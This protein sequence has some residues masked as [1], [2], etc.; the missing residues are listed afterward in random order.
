MKRR[1]FFGLL[2]AAVGLVLFAVAAE[3]H[4]RA[5]VTPPNSARHAEVLATGARPNRHR[6]STSLRADANGPERSNR[7]ETFVE[8]QLED[9]FDAYQIEPLAL[10][11]A[12]DEASCVAACAFD[13]VQAAHRLGAV[14][15]DDRLGATLLETSVRP[16][17]V[18]IVALSL[19][20]PSEFQ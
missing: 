9:R 1:A 13:D 8:T 3:M 17:G 2:S 20:I 12:C 5:A 19:P 15:T 10:T 16:D 14:P 6:A 18:V 11:V 4:H 7:A